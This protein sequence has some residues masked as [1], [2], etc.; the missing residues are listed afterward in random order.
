MTSDLGTMRRM[1]DMVLVENN[2]VCRKGRGLGA[3]SGPGAIH[4]TTSGLH[5]THTHIFNDRKGWGGST[6]IPFTC[7][8]QTITE[9]EH[10]RTFINTLTA[11]RAVVR[12]RLY[13]CHINS[14]ALSPARPWS[15]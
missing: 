14:E 13:S 12:T 1:S 2:Q 9:S 7:C 10:K 6:G 4:K 3:R 8:H 5:S 11:T 15:D